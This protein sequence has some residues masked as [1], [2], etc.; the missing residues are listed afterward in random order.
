[1]PPLDGFVP[2]ILNRRTLKDDKEYIDP[3]KNRHQNPKT[4][5]CFVYPRIQKDSEVESEDCDKYQIIGYAEG[6]LMEESCLEIRNRFIS[7]ILTPSSPWGEPTNPI[8]FAWFSDIS[9]SSFPSPKLIAIK[10]Y[11]SQSSFGP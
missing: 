9:V 2:E 6:Q 7:R 4:N 10:N 1:M 8:F 11:R 3:N 5:A